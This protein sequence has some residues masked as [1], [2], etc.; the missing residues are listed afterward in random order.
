VLHGIYLDL[1]YL[2]VKQLF[3]VEWSLAL[4]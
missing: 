3:D 1:K 4:C 2:D